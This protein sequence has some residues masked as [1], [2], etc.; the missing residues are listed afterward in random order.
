MKNKYID[1]ETMEV[2]NMIRSGAVGKYI[3]ACDI[4]YN[5]ARPCE[6]GHPKCALFDEGPCYAE[7]LDI[8]DGE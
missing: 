6:Y 7:L 2:W 8:W 5:D 3:E 4:H 1:Q